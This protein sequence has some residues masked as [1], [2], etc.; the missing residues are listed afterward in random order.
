VVS[1]ASK[2]PDLAMEL[3]RFLVRLQNDTMFARATGSFTPVNV[4]STMTYD[5]ELTPIAEVFQQQ[6]HNSRSTPVHPVWVSLEE[7]LER[8]IEQALYKRKSPEGALQMID[9]DCAVILKKY[10]DQ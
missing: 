2:D 5:A 10:A 7:A 1:S 4:Q 3:I 6:L 8:G 9:N